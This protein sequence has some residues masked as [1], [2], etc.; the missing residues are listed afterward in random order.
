MRIAQLSTM[1]G[2]YGGEVCLVNLATGLRARGHEVTCVVRPDTRLEAELRAREV[3]VLPLPLR[4]WFDPV[5]VGRLRGWL[6]RADVE[7]LHTHLPRDYF[8]A[9]VAGVGT[10]VTNVGSRHQ[11]HPVSQPVL[12]RPFLRRFGAMIA[13]SEAVRKGWLASGLVDP[14]RVFT[15][16]NGITLPA[17][18]PGVDLR[19]QVRIGP[20]VPTVGFVGRLC[21]GKGIETL[22][23]AAALVGRQVADLRVFVLGDAPGRGQYL[24]H[25]KAVAARHGILERVHFLGYVPDAAR[26]C[27]AFDVQVLCSRAEPFGLVTLEAMAQR[28][29]VVVTDTGGSPEIV[30]DGI[31]G[32]LVPPGDAAALALRLACLL[33]SPGLRAE[34][35]R[36][37]RL[38]VERWFTTDRMV[39]ATEGVYEAALGRSVKLARAASA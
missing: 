21:P 30:R 6:R 33:E 24:E 11:L 37:G 18:G 1:T 22:L 36:R 19:R 29:P 3:P 17:P 25:L 12:K 15:V 26:A 23:Q 34:M 7:I 38:R 8:T 32:F 14:D 13:V 4:H 10:G 27:A 28:R 9:A 31:D 5:G 20:D 39:R 2:Y 16:P 35:G